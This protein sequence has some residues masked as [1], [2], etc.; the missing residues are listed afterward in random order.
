MNFLAIETSTD[1]LSLAVQNADQCWAFEGAGGAQSSATLIPAIMDLLLQAQLTLKDLDAIAFG[2]GPGAF[3]GLRTACAVTQGLALGANLPVLPVDTLLCVA[4][5]ARASHARVLVL[6]DARMHQVYA[7]AYEWRNEQW[8]LVQAPQL[9]HPSEVCVPTDW[10]GQP[11]ALA[12][13][14]WSAADVHASLQHLQSPDMLI[15][16]LWPQA[17]PLLRLAAMAWQRGEAVD[18][19]QA[20]PLYLRDQVALTT[21]ERLALKAAAT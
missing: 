12:G 14:A 6:M 1:R 21:A 19:D 7:A 3:T 4:E 10:Q 9:R 11:F 17:T 2:R 20:L 5:A 8:H 13:N 16:P 18:A 15:L